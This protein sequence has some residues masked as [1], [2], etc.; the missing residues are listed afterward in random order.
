MKIQNALGLIALG[1]ILGTALTLAF[2][3]SNPTPLSVLPLAPAPEST[4]VY[5][6][7][8]E[9]CQHALLE[10]IN[11][12]QQTIDIAIYSF[13]DADIADALIAAKDRGVRVRVVFD[14][15]QAKS[16]Y[17]EDETLEQKGIAIKRLDNNRGILHDKFA[18]LDQKTV[19]TG[20]YNYSE[21]A[22]KYN[23]ENLL[24]LQDR[25]LGTQYETEFEYLWN[26]AG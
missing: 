11:D 6:C 14:S 1:I 5:F 16:Q 9:D 24:I 13:T 19:A 22:R 25:A 4:T 10:Q 3:Q 17:S 12:S 2:L 23:N 8:H 20:S 21:N 15:G 7:P 18:V 26:K